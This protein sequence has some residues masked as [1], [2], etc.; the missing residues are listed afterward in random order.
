VVAPPT[1]PEPA[2]DAHLAL[3]NAR[4]AQAL[5]FTGAGYRIGVIDT[6]INSNHPALQGRVS[7]SFI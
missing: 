6:G 5:G 2:F 4:A 3:T 1:T 7:N